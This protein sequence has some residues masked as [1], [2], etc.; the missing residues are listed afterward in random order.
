MS[1]RTL[2]SQMCFD[3]SALN[4]LA[5]IAENPPYTDKPTTYTNTAGT[6]Q[7]TTLEHVQIQEKC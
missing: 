1:T 2:E 5:Y 4:E 3:S 6:A 7:H